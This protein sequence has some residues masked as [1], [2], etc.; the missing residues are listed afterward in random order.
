MD[1]TIRERRVAGSF[2]DPSGFVFRH[3]GEFY[4]QVNLSFQEDWDL[5]SQSGFFEDQISAGRLIPH[6]EVDRS[7]APEPELAYKVIR[8]EQIPFISY[9]YCWS[10][11]ML[12]DAALL[13]L[14][15]AEAALEANLQLKD[16]SAYNVQFIDGKPIFIDTLSFERYAEG[17]PWIGYGQFCRHFLAPL[18]LMALV[19]IRLQSLL[20]SHIDGIPLDLTSK[21]LPGTS[22]LS[23]GL[24][25]H[26]HALGKAEAKAVNTDQEAP[27]VKISKL[28]LRAILDSLRGTI[29]GL[30]WEPRG[31]E[32]G[33]YY[34][35]TNYDEAAMTRKREI[36]RLMVGSVEPKVVWDLGANTGEFSN[37]AAGQGASVLSWDVD[38]AAVEKHY[39]AI[40]QGGYKGTMPYLLDLTNPSPA[41]GW[42]NRERQSL[43]E[44]AN[45]D[46]I[47]ALALIHHL[48]IGNNVPL[49]DVAQF[50]AE[51]ADNLVLEFVPK[52][53]SQVKRMLRIRKDIFPSYTEEGLEEAFA[54]HW[55]IVEKA[56]IGGTVRTLYR[57][58]RR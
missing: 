32:W 2:R 38:P 56:A 27:K 36:V 16:A 48:A 12:K 47:L 43:A 37:L 10:F 29:R 42:A 57:M 50:F 35:S 25:M 55:K 4:R 7:L 24:A 49:G 44:R 22:K 28:Q 54:K 34:S 23:P 18:A 41:L 31:T 14:D 21:L 45:A 5:V 8:P 20:T 30:K 1:P 17:E 33:D 9:P 26:V 39:L 51:L 15:L 6:T 53:D 13:T 58:V 3:N 11:G 52:E 46:L 19:D 40:K